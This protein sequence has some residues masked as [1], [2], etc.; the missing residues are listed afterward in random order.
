MGI[1]EDRLLPRL[2]DK[3]GSNPEVAR[4]RAVACTGL[5]G[6]VLEIGFGGGHNLRHYP[7]AVTSVLAVEPSDAGWA[8]SEKRRVE[9][10]LT[11]LRS[12]LDGQR[13]TEPDDSVDCV[14][15]TLTL[16]T[17]PNVEAALA[18]AR[19]VL[20]PG[21]SLHF[22]EHGLA[23]D[24]SVVRWQHRLDPL[25]GAV[26]G[27]C[28]LARDIPRLIRGAGFTIDDLESAYLPGPRASR[29]WTYGYVGRATA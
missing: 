23:P 21:G 9:S 15:S 6:V 28:H 1:W 13:L 24:P 18:E 20:R 16:C 10:G 17:I 12:G 19:R 4:M 27:G 5:H 8:L 14:L 29:P 3:A 2:L 22:L 26:F 11:V 7:A 25:Q